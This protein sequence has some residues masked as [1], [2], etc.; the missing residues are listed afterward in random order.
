[1]G[2][3]ESHRNIIGDVDEVIRVKGSFTQ[4]IYEWVFNFKKEIPNQNAMQEPWIGQD[5]L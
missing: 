2:A 3:V 4:P 1:M 5:C